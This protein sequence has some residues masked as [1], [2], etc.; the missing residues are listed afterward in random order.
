MRRVS[1]LLFVTERFPPDRGGAAVSALRQARA[2]APHLERLD[3]LRLSGDLPGG[4]VRE[5]RGDGFT[6]TLVGRVRADDESLQLLHRVALNLVEARSHDAVLGFYAVHAGYVATLVAGQAG[7]PSL[8]SLR[9]NDLDRAMFHG[10]RLPF[11]LQALRQAD[12]V[13]GVSREILDKAALLSG[14]R[15]GLHL[16]PNA[17][18][19]A[20]FRPR[21]GEV[22]VPREL[23]EAPRPFVA[24]AG[25]L[26]FKKGLPVIEAL[27]GRLAAAGRGSLVL[28]GGV[29][30]EEREAFSAW[31]RREPAASARVYERPYEA[32][33]DR[34]AGLCAAMDLFVFPSLWD[35]LP[36]ALLEAMACARP[37][38]AAAVG[39][40]PEVIEDGRSG[41]LVPPRD[42]DSFPDRA[43][44]VLG[45]PAA[46]E[47]VGRAARERV[48]R[49]FTPERERDALLGVLRGLRA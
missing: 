20:R 12:A 14:R 43:L 15:E 23:R 34:L 28:L 18:D 46:C 4:E 11:L 24:F 36:N 39:A 1:R 40:I 45:D 26:R 47:R 48:L 13:I 10:P 2:I 5:E 41:W 8:V 7:V 31:R 19:A 16:V 29:R 49:E 17:V 33:P 35:G 9:G 38:L 27:A 21:E 25:E 30:R 42:L 32:D 37:C 6:L 22:E 44:A 3:V